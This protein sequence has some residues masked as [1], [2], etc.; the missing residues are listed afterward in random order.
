MDQNKTGIN[1]TQINKKIYVENNFILYYNKS[2][3]QGSLNGG[4]N[5]DEETSGIM[6]LPGP[7]LCRKIELN[8]GSRKGDSD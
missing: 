8:G 2:L 3:I 6:Y 5:G 1:W 4:V 7:Q